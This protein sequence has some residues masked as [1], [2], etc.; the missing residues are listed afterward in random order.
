MST[1]KLVRPDEL[2]ARIIAEAG[3]D[4]LC[5]DLTKVEVFS[6][7]EGGGSWTVAFHGLGIDR[8]A[9]EAMARILRRLSAEYEVAWQTQH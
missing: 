5:G 1:K 2:R 9:N 6:T 4:T 3:K 7:E 8:A